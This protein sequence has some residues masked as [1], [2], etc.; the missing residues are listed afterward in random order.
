MIYTEDKICQI[1][2]PLKLKSGEVLESYNLTY[3]TH[4]VL[5]KDS[6]NAVL[7]CHALNASHHIAGIK[8]TLRT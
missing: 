6:N 2:K 3:E 4:G 7:V 8:K 5:S 1:K